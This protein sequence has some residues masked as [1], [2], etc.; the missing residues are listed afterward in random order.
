MTTSINRQKNPYLNERVNKFLQRK[1]DP[2]TTTASQYC[3][4]IKV[5][6]VGEVE[7]VHLGEKLVFDGF[8][9]ALYKPKKIVYKTDGTVVYRKFI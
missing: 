1:I 2:K 9:K 5:I 4:D 3:G 7:L 8:K 6:K